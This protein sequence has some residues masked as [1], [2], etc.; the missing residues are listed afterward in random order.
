MAIPSTVVLPDSSAANKNF[1]LLRTLP[2]GIDRIMDGSTVQQPTLISVR[3]NFFPAKNGKTA[4]DRRTVSASMTI[5]DT[6]ENEHVASCVSALIVP[7]TSLFTS[8]NIYD[9]RAFVGTFM[10]TYK[11]DLLLGKS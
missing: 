3:H 1:E 7:R 4:Y 9:L 8:T 10:N 5:I 2:N 11:A 6:D